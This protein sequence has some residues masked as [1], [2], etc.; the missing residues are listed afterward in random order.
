MQQGPSILY[1]MCDNLLKDVQLTYLYKSDFN[2]FNNLNLFYPLL[3]AVKVTFN[4]FLPLQQQPL[5][6]HP[7]NLLFKIS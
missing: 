7:F 3:K 4:H 6:A 5:N 1:K 2:I